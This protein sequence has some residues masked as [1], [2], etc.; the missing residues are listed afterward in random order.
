[1]VQIAFD[2]G[3][4]E[5]LYIGGYSHKGLV[6]SPHGLA[7]HLDLK[8]CYKFALNFMPS[9]NCYLNNELSDWLRDHGAEQSDLSLRFDGERWHLGVPDSLA[10]QFKL[11]WG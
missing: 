3:W 1:M 6:E 11:A 4:N 9:E 2:T 10:L 8:R 7:L 5:Q